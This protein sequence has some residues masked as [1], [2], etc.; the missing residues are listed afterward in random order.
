MG[1]NINIWIPL[2]VCILLFIISGVGIFFFGS[3]DLDILF[4]GLGLTSI[5]SAAFAFIKELVIKAIDHQYKN[6]SM[7]NE[8]SLDS[9]IAFDI[10]NE[11]KKFCIKYFKITIE[12]MEKMRK[13]SYSPSQ[14][15]DSETLE[16]CREEYF[17]YIPDVVYE[18]LDVFEQA[19]RNLGFNAISELKL[20]YKD[21][22]SE[23]VNMKET[24][25]E[26]EKSL[27][28]S[29]GIYTRLLFGKD[30]ENNHRAVLTMLK[31]STNIGTVKEWQDKIL[32]NQEGK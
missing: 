23:N 4:T 22:I 18:E 8:K 27:A 11:Y 6:I 30:G 12:I 10:Y 7:I 31:K 32:K 14:L 15:A 29:Y 9:P 3:K 24:H 17:F 26:R 5:V 2:V 20:L 16:K 21:L 25:E 28:E 1:K 13:E 19:I